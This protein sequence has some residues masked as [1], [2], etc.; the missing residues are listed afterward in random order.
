MSHEKNTNNL[1]HIHLFNYTIELAHYPTQ[2]AST[3][4]SHNSQFT[5]ICASYQKHATRQ[6][7]GGVRVCVRK[8]TNFSLKNVFLVKH[9]CR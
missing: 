9:M 3:L 5:M 8:F 2:Q 6:T 4:N 1:Y 7:G